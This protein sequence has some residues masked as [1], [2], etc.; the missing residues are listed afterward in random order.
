MSKLIPL[1]VSSYTLGTEV[2]FEE[3][4]KA[5]KKAGYEGIGLRAENYIDAMHA[6]LKDKDLL[7]ILERHEMQVTEVEYITMWGCRETR[8]FAQQA[9]EQMCF[10]MAKLFGVNH[11][12]IGLMEKLPPA[13]V[14]QALKELCRRAGDLMIGVEFMPYSGIPTLESAWE[15]VRGSGCDNAMLIFDTWHWARANQPYDSIAEIPAEKVVSIQICD[16]HDRPYAKQVL[17][18]ESMHDRL[19]PGIGYGDTVGFVKMIKEHGISPRVIGVEV[20]SDAN[21]EKGV[22][23]AAQHTYDNAVMVLEK[24]WPEVLPKK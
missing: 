12:N 6:G 9:K 16:V 1:T 20:I 14:A 21:V 17:R 19:A 10:H 4:V 8:D 24:A 3:R 23:Y 13:D 2:S 22:D 5:A 11:I 15:A 7:E 18:D